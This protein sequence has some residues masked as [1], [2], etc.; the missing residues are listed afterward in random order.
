MKRSGTTRWSRLDNAA[1]IFP[2]TS[3]KH[4]TKVFRFSCELRDS[5]DAQILQTALDKTLINFP[6]YRSILK[7]GLFWYYLED[8]D[9]EPKV[10]E[11]NAPLCAP[12]Y[13]GDRKNLLFNV[14]Y[15][16]RRINLEV[17]H[18][19]TDGTGALNFLREM[20]SH[21]LNEKYADK[22]PSEQPHIDND[23]SET[24][25][26][27]DSFYKYYSG[28]KHMKISR[29]SRV[30]HVKG[31]RSTA[32]APVLI[33]GHISAKELLTA[34]HE[35]GATLTAYLISV[36]LLAIRDGMAERSLRRPIVVTVPVNLRNY[37]SSKSARN[38]FGVIDVNYNFSTDSGELDD[39]IR[40]VSEQLKQELTNEKLSGRMSKMV[41]LESNYAARVA[42]IV[43]KDPSMKLAYYLSEKKVT[44][45]FSNVGRVAMPPEYEQYIEC[46]AVSTVTKR[47][48]AC[49]CSY[50]DNFVIGITSPFVGHETECTFFRA[51]TAAGIKVEIVTNMSGEGNV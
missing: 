43:I 8:S 3:D 37:F 50:G 6:F 14:T 32:D 11:E 47:I 42:P 39:V 25:R 9:L 40:S 10:Q 26:R 36:L 27:D 7:K 15:F 16:A 49:M 24:Q 18:A 30:Y 33:E 19:L 34:A 41:A 51:L 48:Q 44:A 45:A 23:A 28:K 21:Y 12:L 46:F 22:L 38:F 35:H 20:I 29:L 17:Y 31:E 2:P 4:D 1:K 13:S 5:V